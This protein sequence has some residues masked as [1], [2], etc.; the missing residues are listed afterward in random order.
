QAGSL[1][2]DN[3][4]RSRQDS[5]CP[6]EPGHEYGAADRPSARR[7][8]PA[9]MHGMSQPRYPDSLP[10]TPLTAPPA[11]SVTPP[12]SKSITNRALVLAALTAR[13]RPQTAPGCLDSEDVTVMQ[14]CL[15]RLGYGLR[16]DR[17]AVTVHTPEPAG[18][19]PAA[20]AELFVGNSGTTMRF[21]TALAALGA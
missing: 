2:Y 12:G 19:V 10:V 11:A 8:Q 18:L 5:A 16:R 6:A 17:D 21:L 9:T 14:E 1:C 20:S 13:A 3:G 4:R 15:A 7:P